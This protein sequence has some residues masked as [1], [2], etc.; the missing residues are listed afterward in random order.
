LSRGPPSR[1]AVDA[2]FVNSSDGQNP[3]SALVPPSFPAQSRPPVH[4][5]N[6]PSNVSCFGASNQP[7]AR[8]FTT[9]VPIKTGD[10]SA[11]PVTPFAPLAALRTYAAASTTAARVPGSS[12]SRGRGLLGDTSTAST[13]THHVHRIK[14]RYVFME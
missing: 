3:T 7:V 8:S 13:P 10:T 1:I 12:L 11:T 4:G 9:Y 14:P 2:T 6:R 5:V